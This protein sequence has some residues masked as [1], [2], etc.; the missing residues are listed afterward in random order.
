MTPLI[1]AAARGLDGAVDL[2]LQ[3]LA[4]V[5]VMLSLVLLRRRCHE[6]LQW[7]ANPAIADLEGRT[8]V[9]YAT[10]LGFDGIV[11]SLRNVQVQQD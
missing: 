10:S 3:A 7:E 1:H 6:P 2:L 5:T 11:Q 9:D 8:A 4:I